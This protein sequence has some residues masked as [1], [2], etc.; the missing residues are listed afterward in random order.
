VSETDT[1]VYFAHLKENRDSDETHIYVC[2]FV[3]DY[4]I[5]NPVDLDVVGVLD[6]F[7]RVKDF[8]DVSGDLERRGG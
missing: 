8:L 3:T 1:P 2:C 4:D 6:E 5:Y 7:G